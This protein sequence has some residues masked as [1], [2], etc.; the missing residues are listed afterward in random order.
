MLKI[1]LRSS[2]KLTRFSW[3]IRSAP[4]TTA[5]VIAPSVMGPVPRPGVVS[6]VLLILS[7]FSGKS[8]VEAAAAA[9]AVSLTKFSAAEACAVHA[10][11]VASA[12][13][14]CATI[15]RSRSKRLLTV[16]RK[17][18]R[19]SDSSP[20]NPAQAAAPR[21]GVPMCDPARLA[22][23]SVR[24]SRAAD[25]SRCSKPVRPAAEPARRSRIPVG[26]VPARGAPKAAAAS[27]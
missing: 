6:A 27:S 17:N 11:N 23:V 8:S 9:A 12:A 5:M 26:I 13:R 10:A 25:F 24:S 3:T 4:P 2:G 16:W 22:G 7:I 18:S 14:T 19:S 15:S 21:A 20:A 1:N